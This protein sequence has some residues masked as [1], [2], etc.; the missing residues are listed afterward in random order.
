MKQLPNVNTAGIRRNKSEEDLLVTT[1]V[2]VITNT[3]H[4]GAVRSQNRLWLRSD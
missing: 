3:L 4:T 2:G 1:T